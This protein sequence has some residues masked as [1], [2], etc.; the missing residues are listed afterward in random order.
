MATAAGPEPP[1]D[2][3]AQGPA[4]ALAEHAELPR[5]TQQ[6]KKDVA[7]G[8]DTGHSAL[9]D[10]AATAFECNICLDLAKEPV[11]TL[12]GHLFCWPCLYR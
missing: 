2:R 10:D 5:N 4:G 11:V 8:T 6:H 7:C 9:D 12:C 3:V 1:L